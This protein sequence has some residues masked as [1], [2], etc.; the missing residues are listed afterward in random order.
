MYNWKL[1]TAV[2][3]IF[4]SRPDTFRAVFSEVRKARPRILLLWQDGPRKNNDKDR[5]GIIQCREIASEI[6]WDC[7]VY[8]KYNE[9]NIG[10]DPSTF[11]AHKWAFSKVDKC[12]VLEDDFLVD[13]SFFSY[14]KELLDYYENDERI[15]HICGFNLLGESKS[16]PNDYLFSYTGSGA[17]ASWKR[18]I[19]GWD[20]SYKYLHDDY[21]MR[22][23]SKKYGKRFKGWYRK[24]LERENL[25]KA[26]WESI[27]GF[28]CILNN[29]YAIIPKV[30]LVSNI[31]MTTG[32]THSNTQERLLEKSQKKLFYNPTH[33]MNF[34]IKHPQYI[35]PDYDYMDKL[36]KLMGNGHSFLK[37]YRKCVYILKC[38]RYGEFN[39]IV[40]GFKKKLNIARKN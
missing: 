2:L 24:A 23:L 25:G 17:W 29:R 18:V 37:I 34:P 15:N 10:C 20:E 31:G 22:N 1:D 32:S 36:D 9:E 35:V 30:N 4:F 19:E 28:D 27:L 13:Q 5:L 7:E 38:I 33:K 11:M 6:D 21:Y 8:R 14:C 26:Y 3:L 12:I 16:C 39:R 40:D